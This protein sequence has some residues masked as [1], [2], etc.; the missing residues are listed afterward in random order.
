MYWGFLLIHSRIRRF[1]SF[2][3]LGVLFAR[4]LFLAK[5]SHVSLLRRLSLNKLS[6]LRIV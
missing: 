6:V 2:N 1:H 4:S 3:I 5:I